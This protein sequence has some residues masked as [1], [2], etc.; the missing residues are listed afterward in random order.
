MADIFCEPAYDDAVYENSCCSTNDSKNGG[1]KKILEFFSAR[2]SPLTFCYLL[3]EENL[4]EF[5]K[6]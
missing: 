2:V 3:Y 6:K 5:Q 1:L 4:K